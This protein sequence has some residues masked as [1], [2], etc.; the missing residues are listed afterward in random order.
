M[1]TENYRNSL[2]LTY[3][4]LNTDGKTLSKNIAINN[5]NPD[6]TNEKAYEVALL[7]KDLMAYGNEKIIRKQEVLLLEN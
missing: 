5:L 3:K 4:A 1:R 2:V 6:T 7:I